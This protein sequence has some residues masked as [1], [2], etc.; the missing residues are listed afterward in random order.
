[1]KTPEKGPVGLESVL[2]EMPGLCL[3]KATQDTA[4]EVRG[5]NPVP[6]LPSQTQIPS[7][8]QDLCYDSKLLTMVGELSSAQLEGA[9]PQGGADLAPLGLGA[10]WCQRSS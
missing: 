10:C 1:M 5:Q 8:G 9:S 2:E 7:R 4:S 6:E 3:E